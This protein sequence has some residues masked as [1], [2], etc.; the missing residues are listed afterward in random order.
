MSH[1][2][3]VA[4]LVAR[5]LTPDDAVAVYELT[6]AAEL[7]DTG[8]SM[9]ELEDVRNDWSRPSYELARQS[10]GYLDGR[11]LVAYGEVHRNR[12]EA[13]VHP[14]HRG[15]GIGTAMYAWSVDKARELGYDKVGQT[16]PAS[17]AAAIALF[18]R[19]GCSL[20]YTSWI[21][22]LPEGAAIDGVELPAGHRLRDFED[23]RDSVETFTMFEDAFNEWP[24]R[25]PATLED[26]RA[27]VLGR[28]G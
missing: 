22:E 15:R 19:H 6:R 4:A 14:D 20:L 26:W 23:E 8:T 10:I 12:R 18:T 24:N 25:P 1:A 27:M 11:T 17:N 7:A 28:S 13:Y 16:V 21:L 3:Q 9:I 2:S 5:P